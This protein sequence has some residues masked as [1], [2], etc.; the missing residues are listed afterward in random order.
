MAMSVTALAVSLAKTLA[1]EVSRIDG[2]PLCAPT[3]AR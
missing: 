2:K 1:I 3:A